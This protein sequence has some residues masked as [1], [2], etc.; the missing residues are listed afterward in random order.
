LF[1]WQ[2]FPFAYPLKKYSSRDAGR[3][4]LRQ[5]EEFML[6]TMIFATAAAALVGTIFT[7]TDAVAR[8][9]GGFHGGGLGG[10]HSRAFAGARRGGSNWHRTASRGSRFH[11]SGAHRGGSHHDGSHGT[12]RHGSDRRNAH[13]DQGRWQRSSGFGEGHRSSN[14]AGDWHR[15]PGFG[16]S[17]HNASSADGE[18]HVDR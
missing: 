1:D 16:D 8:G 6:R 9:G 15:S 17:R 5:I 2:Y 4:W 18:W 7:S 11:D 10:F 13:A 14:N 3:A 12:D